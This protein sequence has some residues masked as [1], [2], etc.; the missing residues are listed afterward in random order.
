MEPNTNQPQQNNSLKDSMDASMNKFASGGYATD[1]TVYKEINND[2]PFAIKIKEQLLSD[3]EPLRS[4]ME[5]MKKQSESLSPEK[6]QEIGNQ[7]MEAF[8]SYMKQ[9][10]YDVRMMRASGAA[11]AVDDVTK[12]MEDVKGSQDIGDA[13]GKGLEA[14]IGV[15]GAGMLTMMLPMMFM[16]F[17]STLMEKPKETIDKV[18]K[19][20]F[21]ETDHDAIV[22]DFYAVDEENGG[23]GGPTCA[24]SV[25]YRKVSDDSVVF[26]NPI[27]KFM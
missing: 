4:V 26:V 1:S 8:S 13:L 20:R 3:F 19:F 23:K 17:L 25:L 24:G 7:V 14:S 15:M 12:K 9:T 16:G 5:E 6:Q 21:Y 27:E 18:T 11:T 22:V 10:G 2:N